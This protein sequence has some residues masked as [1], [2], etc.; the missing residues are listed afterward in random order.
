LA[1]DP[2]ELV[3]IQV[4]A[5]DINFPDCIIGEFVQAYTTILR[6]CVRHRAEGVIEPSQQVQRKLA[7]LKSSL[8]GIID[9][10][11]TQSP[12]T[13]IAL[14]TYY[15]IAPQRDA[16]VTGGGLVCDL[17]SRFGPPSR[18]ELYEDAVVLQYA[19]NDVIK[20]V[21]ADHPANVILVDL[22]HTFDGREMCRPNSLVFSSPNWRVAHPNAEGQKAI[23]HEVENAV[24]SAISH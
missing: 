3:T 22:T 13:E 4:G 5:D 7:T 11:D 19:L 10:V 21:A 1:L 9:Y 6:G 23:A 20:A 14:L 15:Q 12:S 8:E 16:S 17:I 18:G 24:R 2:P